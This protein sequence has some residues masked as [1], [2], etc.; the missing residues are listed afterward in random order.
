MVFFVIQSSCSLWLKRSLKHAREPRSPPNIQVHGL[1][2]AL[3]AAASVSCYDAASLTT[4]PSYPLE[5]AIC[6]SLAAVCSI[7]LSL[8]STRGRFRLAGGTLITAGVFLAESAGVRLASVCSKEPLAELD[9]LLAALWLC[10]GGLFCFTTGASSGTSPL[11]TAPTAP[12]SIFDVLTFRFLDDT[13]AAGESRQLNLADMLSV[14]PSASTA[15]AADRMTSSLWLSDGAAAPSLIRLLFSQFGR[16]WL[17]L[18]VLQALLLVQ[19][20]AGPLL[21]N[22]LLR[23]IDAPEDSSAGGAVVTSPWAGL[24]WALLLPLQ[25]GFG[26][27]VSTQFSY[28]TQLLQLQIRAGVTAAVFERMLATSPGADSAVSAAL[29]ASDAAGSVINFISVDVQKLM[30]A[31]SSTHQLWSLPVQVTVTLYLLYTQLRWA[32]LAGLAVLVLFTPLN[33]FVSRRIG[34]LTAVMMAH[35]DTRVGATNELLS[36]IRAIKSMVWEAPM[37]ARISCART[38]ELRALTQRKYLDAICVFLWASTPVL[39]SLSTFV[40]AAALGGKLSSADVF[41][42]L[43]LL[44]LLIS[45]MNAFPWVRSIS[46]CLSSR[47]NG[48]SYFD[49]TII[50]PLSRFSQDCSKPGCHAGVWTIFFAP[51]LTL[52]SLHELEPAATELIHARAS[53]SPASCFMLPA[54][55]SFPPTRLLYAVQRVALKSTGDSSCWLLVPSVAASPR[56]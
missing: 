12:H 9:I 16:P 32:F 50:P 24:A 29:E 49:A 8:Y 2:L 46:W 23:F 13:I 53:E 36:G 21:L 37:L 11:P 3:L 18:G 48:T 35:R 43:S 52:K 25:A 4:P 17:F 33:V 55:F 22:A 19:G 51:L 26:A 39:I 30:D 14:P 56:S 7:L 45:P 28:R 41:T 47:Q 42:S 54:R 27:L 40:T 44:S 20:F 31:V 1:S 6:G 34:A 15:I 38:M 10:A 5:M